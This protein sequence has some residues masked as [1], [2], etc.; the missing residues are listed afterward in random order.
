MYTSITFCQRNSIKLARWNIQKYKM[1]IIEV[2]YKRLVTRQE[3]G[4]GWGN[5]LSLYPIT[6]AGFT[7]SAKNTR[8]HYKP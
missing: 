1:N 7:L 6:L 5:K 3:D 2:Q 4:I 8:A